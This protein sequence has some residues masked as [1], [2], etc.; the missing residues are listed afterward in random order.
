MKHSDALR[1]FMRMHEGPRTGRACG[2]CTLCCKLVPVEELHKP[3]GQRCRHVRVAKGCTIYASR[4]LSCQFWSCRWL[5]DPETAAL[6]RPDRSHYVIDIMLD[7]VVAQP[8]AGGESFEITVVQIWLDPAFPEAQ[9]D[10]AL[11]EYM[12]RMCQR[13]G[14]ASILRFD[15]HKATVVFPPPFDPAGQWHEVID[16]QVV[17]RKELESQL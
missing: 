5:I 4:P 1:D 9:H 16:S 2:T 13:Y 10:P 6:P 8:H 7:A 3:A 14:Y 12:L 15:S 11:R 17:P